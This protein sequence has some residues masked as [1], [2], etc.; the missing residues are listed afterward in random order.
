MRPRMACFAAA[1]TAC[2][3][4]IPKIA[5]ADT[6]YSNF[7]AGNTFDTSSSW[8]VSGLTSSLNIAF[9]PAMPFSSSIEANLTQIDIALGNI[10]G[11]NNI[12]LKL[13]TN[14]GGSLGTELGSWSVSN[15]LNVNSGGPTVLT[16]GGIN[17]VHLNAGGNY[18]LQASATGD[19]FNGW[20]LNSTG[21]TAT[22]LILRSD[23]Q[24]PVLQDG[25]LGAF[26]ILATPTSVVPLP[27]ALPL[28]ATGLGA[29][30]LLGWRRKKKAQADAA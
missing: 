15:I 5:I 23:T 26:D 13:F 12:T 30:G 16:V 10:S 24:N 7:G 22:A 27:T 1:V 20:Y 2:I 18:Y 3:F 29:L 19:A 9:A 28:F 4:V 11:G 14:S 17:G 25:T 21:Q 8:I 6:V